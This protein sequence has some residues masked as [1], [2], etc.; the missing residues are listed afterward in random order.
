[1]QIEH[2]SYP[3]RVA[4]N[5]H[6]NTDGTDWGWIEGAPGN[7]CWSN[8][9]GS[10]LTRAQAGELVAQHNAWLE[11]QTPVGVRLRKAKEKAAKIAKD[12]E[13]AEALAERVRAKLRDAEAA[14]AELE[15]E[16][17]Q[18]PNAELSGGEAVRSNDGLGK[19][20]D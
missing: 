10:R 19:I 17:A 5:R 20:G 9:R 1:M 2:N 11:K 12:V 8:N 6:P 7:V 13:D 14:V 18:A 3:W 4:K 16:Q 15:D